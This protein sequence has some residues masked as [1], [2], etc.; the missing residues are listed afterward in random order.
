MSGLEF[1]T[2][3]IQVLAEFEKNIKDTTESLTVE[4][5]ELKSSQAKIKNAVTEMQS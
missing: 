1:K 5:K 3:I 2:I 4:I